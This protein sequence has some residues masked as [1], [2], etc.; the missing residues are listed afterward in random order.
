MERGLRERI[1]GWVLECEIYHGNENIASRNTKVLT[2]DDDNFLSSAQ[3]KEQ[4]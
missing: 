3:V 1:T 2:R 4:F